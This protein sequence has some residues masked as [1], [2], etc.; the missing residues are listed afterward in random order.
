MS[1]GNLVGQSRA[2]RLLL[3]ALAHGRLAHAHVFAGLSGE[4]LSALALNLAKAL[5]C[6]RPDPDA[7]DSCGACRKIE[8][9]NHPDVLVVQPDGDSLKL[10]QI[11]AMQNRAWRRPGEGRYK[12]FILRDAHLLTPE[13]ANSLLKILEDPPGDLI[14]CLLSPNA[15]ALPATVLSRCQ[16][17]QLDPVPQATPADLLEFAEALLTRD[18]RRDEL[19]AL[20]WAEG[21]EKRRQEFPGL[22]DALQ[23]CLRDVLLWRTTGASELLL[24]AGQD[25]FV[26][27]AA[28]RRSQ[29]ELLDG[30]EAV[31]RARR[32]LAH[33]ANFRL[34]A[35]VLFLSL[36]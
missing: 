11:R 17:L 20:R 33:N 34:A 16:V 8:A 28:L 27:S 2:A 22:L 21:W 24:N 3:A 29:E 12:V 26:A 1:L 4:S 19:D 15:Q 13:A 31:E 32:A 5:N 25:G 23:S 6:E 35:E 30:L 9:G 18:A 36:L 10:D 14:I 7:C